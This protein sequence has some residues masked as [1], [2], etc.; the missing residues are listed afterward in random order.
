VVFVWR[1]SAVEAIVKR[2]Q[3]TSWP[4]ALRGLAAALLAAGA[5]LSVPSSGDVIAQSVPPGAAEPGGGGLSGSVS[6]D[7]LE[8]M[9]GDR[10]SAQKTELERAKA[11]ASGAKLAARLLLPCDVSDAAHIGTRWIA[12]SGAAVEADIYEIACRGGMGYF[13]LSRGPDG[14]TGISCLAA[15]GNRAADV[16]SGKSPDLVCQ[17]PENKDV[18]AMAARMMRSAGTD[19]AV[20]DLRWFGKSAAA[21][22]EYSEVACDDGNGFLLRTAMPGTPSPTYVMSCSDAARINLKCRLTSAGPTENPQVDM[23]TFIDALDQHGVTCP[24]DKI[25]VVG[26]EDTRK[27]YV[28]EYRCTSAAAS[29]VAFIPLAGNT[30]PFESMTC[31]QAITRKV[32][33]EFTTLR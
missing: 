16:A 28:V 26:Q 11:K 25:R 8:R 1:S 3:L 17:L 21:H 27:R 7:D 29:T 2:G 32:V 5:G 24:V 33:C 31:E 30:Q 9:S 12:T 4:N 20:K 22:T 19:C 23:K 13:L 6:H 14:P 18:K 10:T 15:E